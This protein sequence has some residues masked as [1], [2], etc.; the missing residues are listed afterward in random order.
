MFKIGDVII[1]KNTGE[2]YVITNEVFSG[3]NIIPYFCNNKTVTYSF[4]GH[5]YLYNEWCH[6]ESY[7]KKLKINK[8][9]KEVN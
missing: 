5:E 7:Y 6:D 4:I 9:K 3:V 2:K 8:I 1:H